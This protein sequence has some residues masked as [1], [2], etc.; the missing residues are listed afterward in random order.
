MVDAAWC[1]G[2]PALI[3]VPIKSIQSSAIPVGWSR[4]QSLHYYLPPFALTK[5]GL[6]IDLA[7]WYLTEDSGPDLQ[8]SEQLVGSSSIS[9]C[10]SR[11]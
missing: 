11:I 1:I 10:P 9:I 5:V 4:F 7:R 2:V 6:S 3:T 8:E